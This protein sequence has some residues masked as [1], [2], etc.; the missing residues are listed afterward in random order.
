MHLMTNVP[1][2]TGDT[3][4]VAV[5]LPTGGVQSIERAFAV[6]ELI[7]AHLA[8]SVSAPAPRMSDAL[9]MDAVPVLQHAA[10]SLGEDLG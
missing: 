3:P 1:N 7:A 8:L 6:L 10:R 5:R 4:Q 9:L 2:V